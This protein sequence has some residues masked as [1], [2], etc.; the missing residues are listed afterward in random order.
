VPLR[1]QVLGDVRGSVLLLGAA[2]GLLLLIACANVANLMLT[3]GTARRRE[4]AVR[5]ALGASRGRLVRQLLVDAAVY[6]VAGGAFGVLLAVAGVRA[7]VALAPGHIPFIDRTTVD[8]TVLAV[9]G[10]LTLVTTAFI[11]AAPAWRFSIA[12]PQI[13]L[14][15][16]GRSAGAVPA[17][18]R[19]RQALIVAEI[20]MAVIVLVAA[21]LLGRSLAAMSR[22]ALGFDPAPTAVAQVALPRARFDTRDKILAFER[23]LTDRLASLP[24]V[25]RA[26]AVYPLPMSGE[27]WSG[28]VIVR[29][30]PSNGPEPDPHAEYSVALPEYFRT[31]NIAMIEGRDFGPADGPGAPWVAIVDEQFARRYW[32]GEP[33]VGK[34]IGPGGPPKDDLGWTTVI[35][36][37]AHVRRASPKSEGE[38]QIYLAALQRAESTLYYVARAGAGAASL[39]AAMRAAVRE[40]DRALAVSTLA[41]MQDLVARTVARDRFN[42]TLLAIFG[43]VALVLATV[44]LYG[45]MAFL[46]AQRTREIGI[47]MALGARPSQIRRAVVGEGLLLAIAGVGLGLACAFALS[48]ALG[49]LLFGI[50]PTDPL[51][52]LAIAALLIATALVASF[53][54]ARRA[55]RIQ[56][57]NSL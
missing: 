24:G 16:A 12:D 15:D 20:T 10:L 33:A 22:V 55:V 26:S 57:S 32:P 54:P 31:M 39:P 56:I 11:G 25:E 36:V 34:Q 8:V 41:T 28:T 21:G 23:Q 27:G 5:S 43:G 42:T 49:G 19:L 46:V 6:A 38:P 51:T 18:R 37:V 2:V 44:G 30:R 50:E 17:R 1:D 7:L 3:R 35:G 9:A 29:G 13:A 4:L 47:R 40:Q 53:A 45:V 14:A 48:R 52:Y